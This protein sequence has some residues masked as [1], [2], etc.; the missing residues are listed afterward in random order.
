MPWFYVDDAFADSKPVMRLD[1]A[2]RNEAVGLWVRCGAWSAKEETDGRVPLDVVRSFNGTPRVI[3]ALHEQAQ[4]WVENSPESWRDSREILF[5]NWSKWQKTRDELI[6]K[7]QEAAERQRRSRDNRKSKGRNAITSD[8]PSMSRVTDGVTERV[9]DEPVS[10]VTN[11]ERHAPVTRDPHARA[12]RPD[13]T[14]PLVE[15]LGGEGHVTN[16]QAEEPPRRCPKHEDADDPPPCGACAEARRAND[17]WAEDLAK[18]EAAAA[19]EARRAAQDEAHEMRA[20]AIARCD[21]CDDDGYVGG[22]LC[23]H[24]PGQAE[25]NRRGRDLVRAVMNG[26]IDLPHEPEDD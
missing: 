9:T 11:G 4:L 3:R 2:I 17:R 20:M 16:G 24:N 10:R 7:R 21:L 13:P 8:D 18:A 12:R 1:T 5:G 22:H 14:R 23:H 19:E 26:E 15:T 6:A 25:T